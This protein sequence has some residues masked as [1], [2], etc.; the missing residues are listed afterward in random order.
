MS[1]AHWQSQITS[2]SPNPKFYNLQN[3]TSLLNTSL[4]HL[5]M[6]GPCGD[7][8]YAI[9]FLLTNMAE[10][11]PSIQDNLHC[12]HLTSNFKMQLKH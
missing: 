9:I 10:K 6:G 1:A 3:I 8:N 7:E 4:W 11:N 12:T 2:K 5:K